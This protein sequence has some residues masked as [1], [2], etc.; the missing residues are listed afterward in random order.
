MFTLLTLFF[1]QLFN[2]ILHSS[3]IGNHNEAKT[4][5]L[6]CLCEHTPW[7][8]SSFTTRQTARWTDLQCH[9]QSD[10]VPLCSPYY[11]G[12]ANIQRPSTY[13]KCS[14]LF[15]APWNTR[16]SK[17]EKGRLQLLR[18]ELSSEVNYCVSGRL[19]K[20]RKKQKQTKTKPNIA[21]LT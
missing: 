16:E 21:Y 7:A 8:L 12:R 2:S 13:L 14:T 17:H 18:S 20:K 11:L 4:F 19:I 5:L 1:W 3:W 15:R 10:R 9:P 6:C